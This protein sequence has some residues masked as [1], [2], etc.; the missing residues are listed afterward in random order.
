M[1][2]AFTWLGYENI[3]STGSD[4]PPPFSC[5]YTPSG[6][7]RLGDGV[8]AAMD[9]SWGDAPPSAR[10]AAYAA[11]LAGAVFLLRMRPPDALESPAV[12]PQVSEPHV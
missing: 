11:A 6:V 1:W 3:R 8:T 7:K 9:S 4:L 2:S 10:L 5:K 12:P